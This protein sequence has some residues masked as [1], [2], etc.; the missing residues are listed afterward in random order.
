MAGLFTLLGIDPAVVKAARAD[1]VKGAGVSPAQQRLRS[2]VRR[3]LL[4]PDLAKGVRAEVVKAVGE[5]VDDADR[6]LD[7][8]VTSVDAR[9]R[10]AERRPTLVQR[11]EA[12]VAEMEKLATEVQDPALRSSYRSMF[13]Q[14]SLVLKGIQMGGGRH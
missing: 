12:K 1:L 8:V 11:Q 9:H 13:D 10:P 5:L 6:R 3:A 4:G 14:E 7:A 2:E